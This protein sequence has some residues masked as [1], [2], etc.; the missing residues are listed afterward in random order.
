LS[1]KADFKRVSIPP[2]RMTP[3]RN[4]WEKIVTTIVQNLKLQIR[5]NTKKKC[6]ELKTS[7]DCTDK[8]NMT[9]ACDFLKAFC[10]G[11]DLNDAIALLRIDD[12]YMESF[13][14]TDVKRLSGDHLSRAIARVSGEKGKTKN[15]IEN[16]TRSR[17][18]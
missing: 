16:A 9:R 10:L 13:D 2:H 12:L 5:M 14:I 7:E 6:V 11:F 17:I 1:E 4:N 3:L 18:V 8:L 15:A